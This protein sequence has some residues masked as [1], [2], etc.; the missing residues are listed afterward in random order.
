ML[1][2]PRTQPRC[3]QSGTPGLDGGRLHLR[4]AAVPNA[5]E[6]AQKSPPEWPGSLH[7][8]G[9]GM[10]AASRTILTYTLFATYL[11]VGALAHDLNFSPLWAILATALVWA[12]PAQMILLTAL[13]SGGTAVQA[14]AAVSLSAIRL[15]PM[16]VALL[17]MLRGPK[18]KSWH[19]FLPTHFVAVTVWV[20][21][22]RL[23]P[24]VPRE[25]RIAF[26]NGLGTG[27]MGATVIS[28]LVGY[29]IAATLPPLF[30]AAVLFLTPISFLL[31]SWANSRMLV[32]RLALV[33]G[34]ALLPLTNL[35]NT[36]VDMLIAGVSAGTVAYAVHRLR[37]RA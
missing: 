10:L 16:V 22:M 15:M 27:V 35:L 33:L 23:V 2:A 18:T 24:Q 28:T 1:R 8:F 34:I 11:G 29:N 20:E 12:A 14:A 9:K 7:A 25:R 5:D 30:G 6:P 19:L 17:P 21:S 32:D 37:A 31:T 4:H 36:G 3:T 26:V 13:G